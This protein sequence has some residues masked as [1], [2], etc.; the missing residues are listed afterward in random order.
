VERFFRDLTQHR[1]R[2]DVFRDIEELVMAIGDY[3]DRHNDQP[4][5]FIWTTTASAILA[6]VARARKAL[7]LR[8]DLRR[9]T[10]V[11]RRRGFDRLKWRQLVR[12]DQ[13]RDAARLT[14]HAGDEPACVQRDDHA[15]DGRW[16][17]AKEGLEIDFRGRAPVQRAVGVDKSQVLALRGG[18]RDRQCRH[19]VIS[20]G[21]EE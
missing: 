4:K 16:R 17:H 13:E 2:R 14:G 7:D 10:L 19:D 11:P 1:L 9:P 5:P 8:C 6:K 15:M 18:K 12:R 21:A 20:S 3:I